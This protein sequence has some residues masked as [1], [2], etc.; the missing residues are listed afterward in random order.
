M[1]PGVARWLAGAAKVARGRQESDRGGLWWL[2]GS[3]EVSRSPGVRLMGP[4]MARW[5]AGAAKV[6]RVRQ[7]SDR[8]GLGWPGGWQE[9]PRWPGGARSCMEGAMGVQ[10]APEVGWRGSGVAR[11]LPDAAKIARGRQESDG[12]GLGWPGG[13]QELPR[14]PGGCQELPRWPG[15]ARSRMEGVWGGQVA[16]KVARGRQ[17]SD[18]GGLGWPGDCQELPRWPGGARSRM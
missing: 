18:G 5:L 13:C 3:Q 15:G 14:W 9:L 8:G 17:E 12:G 10:G 1:G 16:A 7:E 4:V 2:G 6:A 11:W